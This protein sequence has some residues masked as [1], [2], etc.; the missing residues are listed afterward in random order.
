MSSI[1]YSM[2]IYFVDNLKAKEVIKVNATI[3]REIIS[4]NMDAM[5]LLYD[6]RD[7]LEI[8]LDKINKI[9]ERGQGYNRQLESQ[10]RHAA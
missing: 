2:K 1:N 6:A 8:S 3:A 5:S 10:T 9:I 4:N 7:I